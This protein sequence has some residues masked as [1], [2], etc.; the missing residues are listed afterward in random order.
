MK[1][2]SIH[3]LWRVRLCSS[4]NA[5]AMTHFGRKW[6]AR[7]Q[8]PEWLSGPLLGKAR[9]DFVDAHSTV[10]HPAPAGQVHFPPGA[11][12]AQRY[13]IVHLLGRGEMGEV[14]RADDLLLGQP[15]ALK[16][17][18]AAA[19]AG[20]SVLSR[21]RNEVRTAR[22]VS[23]PSVC[24]VYDIGEADGLTYLSME[25]VDGEDLA[26]L[27]RRIGKPPPSVSHCRSARPCRT[28]QQRRSHGAAQP[29]KMSCARFGVAYRESGGQ[30]PVIACHL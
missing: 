27:L 6:S 1:P 10:T 15:V 11:I 13:R 30:C 21:F 12:L 28:G 14:Y 18:P 8:L 16:F 4:A 17:L 19:T 2:Q 24:R 29:R 23:H 3:R 9:A 7:E 26:S 25:Y 22:Q 5:R 20:A